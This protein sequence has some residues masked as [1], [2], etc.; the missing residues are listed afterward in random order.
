MKAVDNKLRVIQAVKALLEQKA[1]ED[2]TVSDLCVEAGVSRQTFYR[3]FKDKYDVA[4][5]YTEQLTSASCRKIGITLGWRD[6]YLGHFRLLANNAPLV[7]GLSQSRDY[8]SIFHSTIRACEE[9]LR[10]AYR[11][12]SGLEPDELLTFQIHAFA[13]TATECVTEWVESDCAMPPEQFINHFLTLIPAE[14]F[15][16]LD[17]PPNPKATEGFVLLPL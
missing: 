14:L 5:W 12:R 16:A 1:F 2:L 6:G 7:R 9:D 11:Q 10:E 13:R 8:N 3:C 15:A 4:M 17:L